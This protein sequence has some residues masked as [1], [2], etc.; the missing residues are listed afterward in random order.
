MKST[1]PKC[2]TILNLIKIKINVGVL[3]TILNWISCKLCMYNPLYILYY[4]NH[5]KYDLHLRVHIQKL[6][7]RNRYILIQYNSQKNYNNCLL[8]HE[9]RFS[10]QVSKQVYTFQT[11]SLSRCIPCL[12]LSL[13]NRHEQTHTHPCAH[14]VRLCG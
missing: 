7:Y 4:I 2:P 1:L 14:R 5:M 6:P 9:I 12:S 10:I 11:L 3:T 13:S 8:F